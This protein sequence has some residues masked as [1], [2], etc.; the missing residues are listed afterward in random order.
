M[1]RGSLAI[2]LFATTTACGYPSYEFVAG[3]SGADVTTLDSDGDSAPVADSSADT[4]TPGDSAIDTSSDGEVTN[5]SGALADSGVDG[6]IDTSVDSAETGPLGTCTVFPASNWWNTAVDGKSVDP[7]SSTWI[8]NSDPGNPLK[9]L[10]GPSDGVPYVIVPGSQPLVDIFED[11]ATG[12]PDESDPGPMPIPTDAPRSFS[13]GYL[14]TIDRDACVL[15]EMYNARAYDFTAKRYQCDVATRWRLTANIVRGLGC[16]SADSAGLPIFPGL[17]RRDEFESGAI[18]H[19]LRFQLRG[20]AV[21]A[22]VIAPP[23]SHTFGTISSS[24]STAGNYLPAAARVRLKATFDE[25]LVPA[26]YRLIVRTLKKYGMLLATGGE[27][28]NFYGDASPKWDLAALTA[29]MAKIHGSDFEVPPLGPGVIESK[30]FPT[31]VP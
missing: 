2:T 9:P 24:S 29:A 25:T 22:A 3:D 6:V 15:Y 4:G 5:D 11:A 14:I 12:Y 13:D 23:G 16:T 17:L 8:G 26:E 10:I 19:A 28:W 21:R 7:M 30:P 27:S 20:S 18:N 31:C 1:R